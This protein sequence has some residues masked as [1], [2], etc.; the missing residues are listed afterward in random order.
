MELFAITC[1]TCQQRLKVRD[2]S[3]IGEIQICPKCGSMVL[4]EPPEAWRETRADE[5]PA[6]ALPPTPPLQTAS[7]EPERAD[8]PEVASLPPVA[9]GVPAE[10]EVAA[11]DEIS[12]GTDNIDAGI[13]LDAGIESPPVEPVPAPPLEG[14][15]SAA[16]P[17]LSADAESSQAP[18]QSRQWLM[19]GGAAVVGVA[20]ALGVLGFFASRGA[21]SNPVNPAAVASGS[22][23]GATQPR[24]AD[25]P[26][27]AAAQP[28][29]ATPAAGKTTEAAKAA[30]APAAAATPQPA[31]GPPAK[32]SDPPS[33]KAPSATEAKPVESPPAAAQPGGD[34]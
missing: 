30:N 5:P 4:V 21:K 16:P 24:S 26:R 10:P 11:S 32:P 20:L 28:T 12:A 34:G 19:R 31:D 3:T 6:P 29:G 13:E 14:E 15:G 25:T 22:P 18:W 2:A 1:T 8:G 23:A 33:A 7:A 9:A 27:P 17:V